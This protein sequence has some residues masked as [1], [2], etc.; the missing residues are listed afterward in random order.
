MRLHLIE[1]ILVMVNYQEIRPI[2]FPDLEQAFLDQ[3]H[4]PV[5]AEQGGSA[6]N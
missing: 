2:R 6:R 5:I 1:F 3:K 4:S